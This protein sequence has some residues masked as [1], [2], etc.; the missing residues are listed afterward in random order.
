MTKTKKVGLVAVGGVVCFAVL[1]AALAR[2]SSWPSPKSFYSETMEAV[3]LVERNPERASEVF[4]NLRQKFIDSDNTA[5]GA[6]FFLEGPPI[7]R[8]ELEWYAYVCFLADH[9]VRKATIRLQN[10]RVRQID[11]SVGS[12]YEI[13]CKDGST[14]QLEVRWRQVEQTLK[15]STDESGTHLTQS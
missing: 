13:L 8:A 14:Q 1:L 6:A 10:V 7:P 3:S 12:L 2:E 5:S 4:G 11:G 15:V 9:G